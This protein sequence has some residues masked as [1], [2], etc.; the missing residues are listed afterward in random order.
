MSARASICRRNARGLVY[1]KAAR[2]LMIFRLDTQRAFDSDIRCLRDRVSVPCS[3]TR[4][5]LR[6]LSANIFRS[7]AI[8]TG[9]NPAEITNKLTPLAWRLNYRQELVAVVGDSTTGLMSA[10]APDL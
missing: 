10:L 6:S 1:T 5:R 3:A 9:T 2:V 4:G 8:T 7:P